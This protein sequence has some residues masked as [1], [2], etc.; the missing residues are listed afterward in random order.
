MDD[1]DRLAGDTAS[2]ATA[3]FS[4]V[5]AL[6]ADA[7]AR[8]PEARRVAVRRACRAQPSMGAIWNLAAA[9]LDE[10]DLFDRL[11]RRAAR[12]TA[13]AAR[14]AAQLLDGEARRVITCSRSAAVEASIRAL[15]CPAVCAES[16]PALEGRALAASLAGQGVPVTVVADAAIASDLSAGDVVLVGAD[17]IAGGW[18]INKTGTG[19]LCAAAFLAGVPAYAVSGREKCVPGSIAAALS[20][21]S[22]DPSP[23]WPDA[24]RGVRLDNAFFERVPLDRIAGVITDAGLLAGDMIAAACEAA[25]PASVARAFLDLLKEE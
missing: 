4:S 24:P 14:H 22:G 9:A 15:A 2:S 12:S 16:R 11:V 3:L 6:L 23:L 5:A 7:R 18:F 13:A 25:V 10:S 1:F 21:R 8:G 19:Q 17:A 20:L